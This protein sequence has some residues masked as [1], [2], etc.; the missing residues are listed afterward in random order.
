M[1][2]FFWTC[3]LALLL[4]ALVSA[5]NLEQ[6]KKTITD[7]L[8]ATLSGDLGRKPPPKALVDACKTV[9]EA[10]EKIHALPNLSQEDELWTLRREAI[11]RIV[12]AYSD[13]PAHYKRL[14]AIS[15]ELETKGPKNLAQETEKH[16]L[17]ICGTLVAE[18][19]PGDNVNIPPHSLAERMVIYAEQYPNAR[20]PSAES[21]PIIDQ[22]FQSVR[23]SG[24]MTAEQRE[25][26]IAAIAPVF[27]LYY[28]SIHHTDKANALAPDIAR[29]SLPGQMMIPAGVDING[30]A[31]ELA[32]VFDKVVLLQ[33]WG[34]WCVHCKEEI[35]NLIKLHEKYRNA[36]FEIIGVNTATGADSDEKVVKR[37]VETTD[38]GG[39]KI[40]WTIL[41]EGLAK[42]QGKTTMTE[43]YGIDRLP[44]LI[45]IGKDG[46]VIK[47]H[48]LPSTLDALIAEATSVLA[49]FTEEERNEIKKRQQ[50]A[51]DQELNEIRKELNKPVP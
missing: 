32:S 9:V 49:D 45:L 14:I 46:V 7:N 13:P 42:K 6:L 51:A 20:F 26:R 4:P 47:L 30:K 37:F 23:S 50:E 29:A 27:Q 3:T 17:R 44:V 12:L 15:D 1:K 19:K 33:F 24:T 21:M 38:F 22:F 41:H 36:G 35:P 11:A 25:R 28:Q 48:P 16:V 31:L 2:T 39:K 5:Q 43:Q 34:T 10:V 40:P 8:P 18:A